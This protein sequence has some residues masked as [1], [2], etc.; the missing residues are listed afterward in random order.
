MH[1]EALTPL[2]EVVP[3]RP[4][5]GRIRV[6]NDT[7]RDTSY[8]IRVVGIDAPSEWRPVAGGAVGAGT[9]VHVEVPILVPDLL[10]TGQHPVG[11]EVTSDQTSERPGL[12][13]FTVSVESVADVLLRV[14]PSIIRGATRGKF[15]LDIENREPTPVTLE[16]VGGATDITAKFKPSEVRL[17]PGERAVSKGKLRGRRRWS[18]DHEQHFVTLTARGRASSTS[19]TTR[20][21]QR[22][23]FP[24]RFRRIVA[25]LIVLA[26]WLAGAGAYVWYRNNKA[27]EEADRVVAE[28]E[29][30]AEAEAEAEATG[31]GGGDTAVDGSGGSGSEPGA[32]DGSESATADAA[33]EAAAQFPT[34][35]TFGGS[36]TLADGADPSAVKVSLDEIPLG[37]AAAGAQPAGFLDGRETSKIWS[38]R[39]GSGDLPGVRSMRQTETVR[40]IDTAKDGTW[41]IGQ[42]ALRRNYEV[43]FSRSGYD[44]Q[45]F[46]V[47]PTEDGAPVELE[48]ELQPGIGVIAGVVRDSNGPIGGVTLVATDGELSFAT[49]SSTDSGKLGEFSFNGLSTPAVY[50]VTASRSGF[51]TEVVQFDLAAGQ[52]RAGEVIS[53]R[54]GVGSVTGT[55]LA[56]QPDASG[57][58]TEQ[59]LG[60][61][62]I[63]VTNGDLVRTVTTLT[64]GATGTF[65]L[66]RLPIPATYTVTATAVG[67][68]DASLTVELNGAQSDAILRL[69]SEFATLRGLVVN[70]SGLPVSGAGITLSHDDLSF[71][72]N[73]VSDDN[74]TGS[75]AAG[76][77]EFLIGDGTARLRE[78]TSF[79]AQPGE[80]GINDLPPGEYRIEIVHFAHEPY[81]A[82]VV[83][84]PGDDQ[85]L[86]IPLEPR[87]AVVGIK[88]SLSVFATENGDRELEGVEFWLR[89]P[90]QA[91]NKAKPGKMPPAGNKIV[92]FDDLEI[93][94]YILRAELE[95]YRTNEILV[96]VGATTGQPAEIELRPF[97]N[98]VIS[99]VDSITGDDL[100][101]Y[102]LRLVEL[103]DDDL[104]PEILGG[105]IN[106]V[107]E[108]EICECIVWSTGVSE[109]LNDGTWLVEVR[110]HPDGYRIVPQ[111]IIFPPPTVD[112]VTESLQFEVTRDSRPTIEIKLTANA[113]PNI[114]VRTYAPPASPAIP[115]EVVLSGF[116]DLTVEL[117]CGSTVYAA[118][119][120]DTTGPGVRTGIFDI[121]KEL[122]SSPN[123]LSERCDIVARGDAY[124]PTIVPF[125]GLLR[126]ASDGTTFD[127]QVSLVVLPRAV[128]VTGRVSW[129]DGVEDV[130]LPDTKI[131]S[132]T[133]VT[134]G[135]EP[136]QTI[137]AAIPDRPPAITEFVEAAWSDHLD[138]ST[139][140][141]DHPVEER[142]FTLSGQVF[143]TADYEVSYPDDIAETLT[144]GTI[145]LAIPVVPGT[146]ALTAP[147]SS[148]TALASQTQA[149]PAVFDYD[150]DTNT[151]DYNVK[152]LDP[153]P[154]TLQ[155]CLTIETRR[156]NPRFDEIID[157]AALLNSG[158]SATSPLDS[159]VLT[160][161]PIDVTVPNCGDDAAGFLRRQAVQL[162]DA[163]AGLWTVEY[164]LPTGTLPRDSWYQF[165]DGLPSPVTD[166]LDPGSTLA[167]FDQTVVENGTINLRV[168]PDLTVPPD[169]VVPGP[170]PELLPKFTVTPFSGAIWGQAAVETVDDPDRIS[171]IRGLPVD[172][173]NPFVDADQSLSLDIPSYDVEGAT[174]TVGGV[175]RPNGASAIS[176]GLQAGDE[177]DVV[178]EV[179]PLGQITGSIK[180]YVW[181]RP[182][183]HQEVA[184]FDQVTGIEVQARRVE[185]DPITLARL[186]PGDEAAW[187]DLPA[188]TD[189]L[190]PNSAANS[191]DFSLSSVQPGSYEFRV[192]A[193]PIETA[194]RIGTVSPSGAQLL[195]VVFPS[196]AIGNG[197]ELTDGTVVYA[198]RNS[199]TVPI[200]GPLELELEPSTLE[201][202]VWNSY[203]GSGSGIPLTGA[204]M[205]VYRISDGPGGPAIPPPP[206]FAVG[207]PSTLWTL[208][209]AGVDGVNTIRLQPDTYRFE[210]FDRPAGTDESYPS[211]IQVTL[212][213][214][215]TLADRSMRIDAVLPSLEFQ[216]A[217]HIKVVN[218]DWQS[219]DLITANNSMNR[220]MVPDGVELTRNWD[221]PSSFVT[222]KDGTTEAGNAAVLG[223]PE[224]LNSS[225]VASG[226]ERTLVFERLPSGTHRIDVTAPPGYTLVQASP[227]QGVGGA[228]PVTLTMDIDGTDDEFDLVLEVAD[229]QVDVTITGA[230]GHDFPNQTAQLYYQSVLVEEAGS[231]LV[232]GINVIR[233]ALAPTVT[234]ITGLPPRRG[235]YE[236]RLDDDLH[237]LLPVSFVE[238]VGIERSLD[239]TVIAD[240]G[241]LDA[242][243]RLENEFDACGAPPFGLAT[244]GPSLQPCAALPPSGLFKV[245]TVAR[246]QTNGDAT[247][248][249][250]ATVSTTHR[251]EVTNGIPYTAFLD[252]FVSVP[253]GQITDLDVKLQ[254]LARIDLTVTGVADDTGV[255]VTTDAVVNTDYLVGPHAGL[256]WTYYVSV[257]VPSI[258]FTV[259]KAGLFPVDITEDGLRTGVTRT[260]TADLATRAITVDVTNAG[261][262]SVTPTVE[263]RVPETLVGSCSTANYCET[264]NSTLIAASAS[265]EFV[266][267]ISKVIP[268]TG[269]AKVTVSAS[270]YRTNSLETSGEIVADKTVPI[271]LHPLVKVSGS[272]AF[273]GAT[274]PTGSTTVV[275]ATKSGGPTYTATVS[276]NGTYVFN[277]GPLDDSTAS[278]PDPRFDVGTWTVTASVIGWGA[279]TSS[280][281]DITATSANSVVVPAITLAPRQI[282]ATLTVNRP[283]S[284]T[285]LGGWEF[286]VPPSTDA[287]PPAAGGVVMLRESGTLDPKV[288]LR[289]TNS[290]WTEFRVDLR[291]ATVAGAQ[292]NVSD[293]LG[294]FEAP[295]LQGLIIDIEADPDKAGNANKVYLIPDCTKSVNGASK[296]DDNGNGLFSF[297]SSDFDRPDLVFNSTGSTSYCIYADGGGGKNA[298]LPITISASGGAL[299]VTKGTL[300][301]SGIRIE[302][303]AL[304][305]PPLTVTTSTA[306]FAATADDADSSGDFSVGDTLTWTVTVTNNSTIP[307]TKVE[308]KSNNPAG[309]GDLKERCAVLELG[310]SCVLTVT[311]VVTQADV[312]EGSITIEGVAKS[313][314]TADT[315]AAPRA[316][317]VPQPSFSVT[318]TV[319]P[320]SISAA[321]TLTYTIRVD[322][323]GT[324]NLTTVSLTKTLGTT[325][326]LTSGDDGD[327]VL[328]TTEVWVYTSTY[329]ATPAG[330]AL[331]NTVSVDTHQTT[332]QSAAAVTLVPPTAPNSVTAVLDGAAGISVSWAAPSKNGGSAIS[333]YT[334]TLDN[335]GGSTTVTGTSA[336]FTG[337]TAATSYTATVTANNAAGSGPAAS[338]ASVTTPT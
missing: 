10:G 166:R 167:G 270:G 217:V 80:F 221:A 311:Y 338:A 105:E 170:Q 115:Q 131:R 264:R 26:L 67:F 138:H 272:L 46:V 243:L 288:H 95:N 330:D 327:G 68:S 92:S 148:T 149:P 202:K 162:D 27:N 289:E 53:M 314:Q 316:T 163:S 250:D 172:P 34:E 185:Y 30:L 244:I 205:R 110:N 201:L 336:G 290:L 278:T 28:Q 274:I 297:A 279:G 230:S 326:S 13:S 66:P 325:P 144:P 183:D 111:D 223:V 232:T 39:Y 104:D 309:G 36:V 304:G 195:D 87:K 139:D 20:F 65:S 130:Y 294:L 256:V 231:D 50:T 135:Y 239:R 89:R 118:A 275:T 286:A 298:K 303:G 8:Q 91:H 157:P 5:I 229:V 83:L 220:L 114:K 31:D 146:S 94:T 24:W 271:T 164:A 17:L 246:T 165:P 88:Q 14:E 4:V 70:D 127:R 319:N 193:D 82:N 284:A 192:I 323:T 142:F 212:P 308:A 99:V 54:K 249:F 269:Q 176:V 155:G 150:A 197:A 120:P 57:G 71:S 132:T 48:V 97:G 277:G 107:D 287:A 84:E 73:T 248:D 29:Q 124:E 51:G 121:P 306:A 320:T 295:I 43:V 317:T 98:V 224:V 81:S 133:A 281:F 42:V 58:S 3:G 302:L 196:P 218:E 59:P 175:S 2:L 226:Y 85:Y 23:M 62:T 161:A 283:G 280:S 21:V 207:P 145:R 75:T 222:D 334:V 102:D 299:S 187:F 261:A 134:T 255:S 293:T 129:F 74:A 49:T 122:L 168:V 215:P 69:I 208:T 18:G 169:V 324:A 78:M 328:E 160:A 143:H 252:E 206:E 32:D 103:R 265:Q 151:Y 214:G 108:Q 300:D 101:S 235:G 171:E 147:N 329:A 313:E 216:M 237:A 247:L 219:A 90:G 117:Q 37:Q 198:M 292:V 268:V 41:K 44:T 60:G 25:I 307:L 318:N 178:V 337:L 186:A 242:R 209:D 194:Y 333:G 305:T 64:E 296:A 228:Y 240:V 188:P 282:A 262:G 12:A 113:F 47:T 96:S 19:I 123:L 181:R 52:A 233:T 331:T 56:K 263:V 15:V 86:S 40:S 253:L 93:G 76:F 61:V 273:V 210:I 119:V 154:G 79:G 55:V 259:A 6:V 126:L 276:A 177:V 33:A 128:A 291:A 35:T 190:R 204:Q 257:D 301:S 211:T 189:T 332:A 310:S 321:G 180:G 258:T 234:T 116:D 236:L 200:G 136:R 156:P 109:D 45:S 241:R 11:V 137:G 22:S 16:L 77:E 7:D 100:D 285:V 174:V 267:P 152:L 153:L 238:D 38:A 9:E 251:V 173:Q 159:G 245:D 315:D 106:P 266:F 191:I 312:T 158:I 63:T 322:N 213:S 203:T 227:A 125:D 112:P 199:E 1:V 179:A 335:G 254:K 260:P 72:S 182:S 140:D 184:G 225:D 141:P